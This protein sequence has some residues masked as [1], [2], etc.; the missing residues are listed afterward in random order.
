MCIKLLTVFVII[1]LVELFIL[2]EIGR[3]IGFWNTVAIQ[4]ITG[5]V[6]AGLAK[7]EG[8]AVLAKIQGELAEGRM[9]AENMVDGLLILAAGLVLLTPGLL[10][11]AA[12]LLLLIPLTRRWVRSRL[13]RRFQ[14]RVEVR[15][16]IYTVYP[17]NEE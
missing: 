11:D 14:S 2:V 15:R 12:G 3:R 4:V 8:L 1:P 9:P 10:T 5:M 6:G 17:E 13:W 7:Y 16:N